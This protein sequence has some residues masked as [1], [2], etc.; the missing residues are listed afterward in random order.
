M[1][2]YH[3]NTI[4]VPDPKI[5]EANR[6]LDFGNGFYTTT[7]RAQADRWAEI[8]SEKRKSKSCIISEY[9]FNFDAAKNALTIISFEK[10]DNEWLDFV[11][12]NRSGRIPDKPYDIAIG[13][14]A[15]DQ[16]FAVVLLYEQ[17]VLSREAA[18]HEMRVRELYDQILFHTERSLDF[19]RYISYYVTGGASNGTG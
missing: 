6:L 1:I 12:T 15:N 13:P 14:V 4:H 19:C 7:N 16:V 10:P 18:I 3:G 17:G 8:V 11:C 2:V 9:E 5:F